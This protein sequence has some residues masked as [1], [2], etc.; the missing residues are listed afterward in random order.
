MSQRRVSWIQLKRQRE[1][2]DGEMADN[3]LSRE[4]IKQGLGT[5][6]ESSMSDGLSGVPAALQYDD[7][8]PGHTQCPIGTARR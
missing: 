3:E 4:E 6:R 7:V 2:E 8:E 5:Q 1:R